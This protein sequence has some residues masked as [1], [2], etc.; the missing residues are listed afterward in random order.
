MP[1]N[2]RYEGFTFTTKPFDPTTTLV[3]D[4]NCEWFGSIKD[5]VFTPAISEAETNDM[6]SRALRK[7]GRE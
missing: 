3:F 2:V 1:S 5:G 7:S 6:L 4:T